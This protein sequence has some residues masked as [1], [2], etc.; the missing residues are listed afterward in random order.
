MNRP[1]V[2]LISGSLASV[3]IVLLAVLLVHTVRGNSRV[4]PDQPVHAAT[5]K[6]RFAILSRHHS[7]KC[8]LRPQSLDSISANGRLQGACCSSMNFE[9]YVRQM[10]GLKQY[11]SVSEI[12]RDPYD[13]SVR[14]AKRLTAYATTIDLAP[15]QRTVYDNAVKMSAEHGPCCCLWVPETKIWVVSDR[16][17]R[18]S[19][20]RA[21]T[22]TTQDVTR[23]GT[24]ARVCN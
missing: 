7:N 3:G 22:Q 17:G 24:R 20:D 10:R 21:V 23:S 11:A 4:V 13:I 19:T 15:Q 8:A 6:D 16:D 12:P 1:R 14:L 18:W 9:R 2:R 5:L